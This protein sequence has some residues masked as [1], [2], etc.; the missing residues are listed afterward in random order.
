MAY[1]REGRVTAKDW[2]NGRR[3]R[4]LLCCAGSTFL[5][6][7][8]SNIVAVSLPSIARD[9]H[10]EFTDVEWVVSAYILP[11]AALLIPAGSLADRIGRRRAL[12]IGLSIF[13]VASA[14]CG[15]APSLLA[16]NA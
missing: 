6:M 3:L 10:G 9:L 15:F 5:I 13:T 4:M 12:A 8:D 16:L 11:F 2:L 14:L 7:L 1:I